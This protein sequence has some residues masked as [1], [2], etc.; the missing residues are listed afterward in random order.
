VCEDLIGLLIKKYEKRDSRGKTHTV[1]VRAGF[2]Y[3]G[4]FD[5]PYNS[6]LHRHFILRE[7]RTR[8]GRQGAGLRRNKKKHQRLGKFRRDVALNWK[9]AILRDAPLL[10]GFFREEPQW[11]EKM[12]RW[13]EKSL[14]VRSK[15]E[16]RTSNSGKR[17][18]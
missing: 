13:C 10:K 18:M 15:K 16:N 1:Q 7:M 5:T 14:D 12:L 11:R 4:I 17:I 9:A 3:P 6:A 2:D 8:T